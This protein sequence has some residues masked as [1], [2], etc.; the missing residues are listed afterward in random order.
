M[1]PEVEAL[2]STI[3]AFIAF[4][5]Y[6]VLIITLFRICAHMGRC[7]ESLKRIEELQSKPASSA[8]HRK[9]GR[10]ASGME[11]QARKYR[12]QFQ[13]RCQEPRGASRAKRRQSRQTLQGLA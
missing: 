3:G 1:S 11:R 4:V 2:Y 13:I 5:Y 12:Q 10:R 9:D 6:V 7:S 8:A